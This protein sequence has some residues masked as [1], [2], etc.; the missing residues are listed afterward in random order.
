LSEVLVVGGEGESCKNKCEYTG[1]GTKRWITYLP[2]R[3]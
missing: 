3:V 2:R 1:G